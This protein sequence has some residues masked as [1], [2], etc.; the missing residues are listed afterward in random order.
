MPI[1]LIESVICM[2]ACLA[3]GDLQAV[4]VPDEALG[5]LTLEAF[6]RGDGSNAEVKIRFRVETGSGLRLGLEF[7]SSG[8]V[9]A[10]HNM[11]L[12]ARLAVVR[13]A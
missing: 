9:G 8:A 11:E 6:L 5:A 2:S 7:G 3:R 10:G 12:K 13:N 1:A 4:L